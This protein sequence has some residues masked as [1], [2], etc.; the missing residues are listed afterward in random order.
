[1]DTIAIPYGHIY[2]F[3]ADQVLTEKIYNQ[4]KQ[5]NFKP[6]STNHQTEDL[7]Y[8][9]E[10]FN[11]FSICIRQVATKLFLPKEIDLPIVA[12][13]AN[14][15]KKLETHHSHNHSNSFMSGIFYLTDHTNSGQTVFMMPN[16][17]GENFKWILFKT[18]IFPVMQLTVPS[19]K[20][21]LLL[22][23]STLQHRVNT[24]ID[25]CDRF[26]IAFNV[27]LSGNFG[28]N[29]AKTFLSI[30]TKSVEERLKEL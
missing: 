13:W 25:D 11:W 19:T 15:T 21:T 10:L 5:L 3:N 22:F 4:V 17:W 23:P 7:Y 8:D 12:C 18:A 30:N 9:E 6:V 20:G 26:S 16:L 28:D 24:L 1:M 2:K 14:K 27:F 29:N